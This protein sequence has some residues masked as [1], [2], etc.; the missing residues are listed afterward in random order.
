MKK[1][2]SKV[3]FGIC[4]FNLVGLM[5]GCSDDAPDKLGGEGDKEEEGGGNAVELMQETDIP[6]F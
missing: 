6:D 2:F 5:A 1:S 3:L 4:L